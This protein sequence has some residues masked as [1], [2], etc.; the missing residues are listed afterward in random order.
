MTISMDKLGDAAVSSAIVKLIEQRVPAQEFEGTDQF[1][2]IIAVELTS[3]SSLG[4]M[5]ATQGL[6]GARSG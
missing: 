4:L 3:A 6:V 2:T 1:S 5:D